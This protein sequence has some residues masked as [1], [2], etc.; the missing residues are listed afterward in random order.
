MS[1]EM[2][3]KN[4]IQQLLKSMPMYRGWGEQLQRL[5]GDKNI[6]LNTILQNVKSI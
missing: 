6:G 5:I 1:G 4:N 2:S 3:K